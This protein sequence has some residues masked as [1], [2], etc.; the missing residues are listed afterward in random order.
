MF[1]SSIFTQLSVV[2]VL[3]GVVSIIMRLLR[4]PLIIGYILTGIVVGPSVL[5]MVQDHNVFEAY[6]EIGITL[7]LFIIGLGL[8]VGVVKSLG[9]VSLTTASAILTLVGGSGV[10]AGVLLGFSSIEAIIIGLSLFFSSTIIIL[11]VLSDKRE[12]NRLHGQ[13]A[14]G[15]ILV[16][17]LVATLALLFV[18]A[19]GS[20]GSFSIDDVLQLLL[21]G[22]G[23]AV[24]LALAAIKLLPALT[25][26]LAGSQELLFV[27][28]IAWGFGVAALFDLVGF[29]HEVGALFAGVSLAGLPY[30][31]EM[32]TRL[33][34]LRDFFIVLFFV[35]LGEN[36]SLESLQNSL[37]PALVLSLIVI[38][39]KPLFVMASLGALGYTKLTSFKTAINLSQVS[40]F[41]IILVVYSASVGLVR[42]ELTSI[43]TLVA[44]VT[45]STS[46][47]LMKYDDKLYALLEPKL[48]HFERKVLREHA[49]KRQSYPIILFGYQ[50]GGH[51][52]VQTFRSMKQRYLVV[53]YDPSIIEHLERQGI[54]NV[55]GDATDEELLHEIGARRAELMVSTIDDIAINRSLL[56]YLRYHNQDAVFLCHADTYEEAAD[57]YKHGATYVMLPH[58]LGSERI[59]SFIKKHGFNRRAFAAYRKTH[60]IKLGKSALRN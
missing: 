2:I 4:Q 42:P 31:T 37:W 26:W 20:A 49:H 15:V 32:A 59:G 52:F 54:R 10:A 13:I 38:T 11:K 21:G 25:R 6:S 18:A 14:M 7:L 46:T 51:E 27:F 22:I 9:K 8:N 29:S 30:A 1:E 47:Y 55:Y 34:P 5:G 23:L 33:K 48:H 50:R 3:V 36:L 12:L 53:D 35:A 58:Y 28:T 16:D 56:G 41:S 40:E 44:L 57:L 39:L 43:I 24:M 60:V 17:D 45:I 19:A